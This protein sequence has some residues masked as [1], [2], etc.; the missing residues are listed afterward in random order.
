MTTYKLYLYNGEREHEQKGVY[1][2]RK[3]RYN[4]DAPNYTSKTQ[5]P[6]QQNFKNKWRIIRKEK[7]IKTSFHICYKCKL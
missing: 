3:T 6:F 4:I 2:F 5:M 1:N 7:H